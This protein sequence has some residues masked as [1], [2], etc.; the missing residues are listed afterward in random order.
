MNSTVSGVIRGVETLGAWTGGSLT[1]DLIFKLDK[2]YF[3][4]HGLAGAKRDMES[5][6]VPQ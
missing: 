5:S 2:D 1:V 3:T 6:V 4:Q